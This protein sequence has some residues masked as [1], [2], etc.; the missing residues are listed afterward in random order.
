[1]QPSPERS[2][3][4]LGL[5]GMLG[6]LLGAPAV[7]QTEASAALDRQVDDAFRQV[8]QQP[9]DLA[10][11]SRYAQLLIQAGNYEGGI[12]A[13]ERLLLNPDPS[14]ELRLDIALLYYRLG[15][16]A[17]AESMVRAALADERL[18]A[19]KRRVAETLLADT[20]RRNQRSQLAGSFSF[21]LRHQSNPGYRTDSGLVWSGGL[22]G[23]LAPE[24]RPQGDTDIN[25]GLKLHHSYDLDRQNSAAI[26]STLGAYLVDYRG[27]SGSDLVANPTKP[28]DLQVLELTSGLQFKP[29]P[30]EASNLTLRPHLILSNVTAQGHQFLRNAGLG[31]DLG[32]R[33]SERTLVELVLD[34]QHRDFASRVDVVNADQLGGRLWGLRARVVRELAPGQQLSGEYGWR[35]NS[36]ARDYYDYSSHELR[37]TYALTY[38][39]PFGGGSYWTTAVTLGA[40]RRAYGGPDPTITAA[41]TRRDREWRVGVNQTVQLTPVWY[42]LFGLEQVRND[43]N[44]PNF[45]YKNTTLSGA[46]LRTF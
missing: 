11:W 28:Y 26:V 33:P 21:G 12:A 3:C 13:L 7:A 5:L 25:L 39:A 24:Q 43:A 22:L 45:R 34:G 4:R 40:L 16:Y 8:Q 9:Q 46:V 1:M 19:D 36:T 38:A 23:P 32:W 41:D 18:P 2:L 42:L 37:L 15:S 35:R 30:I 44:L 6:A 31:L 29:L 10:I 14:P 17:M 27:T 20:L